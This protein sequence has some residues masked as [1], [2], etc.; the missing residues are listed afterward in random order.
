MRQ[1]AINNHILEIPSSINELSPWQLKR[2]KAYNLTTSEPDAVILLLLLLNPR[3]F[4]IA[5][6]IFYQLEFRPW[7][8]QTLIGKL[9]V[10]VLDKFGKDVVVYFVR[11]EPFLR[12]IMECISFLKEDTTPLSVKPFKYKY[13]LQLFDEFF[14]G[15]TMRQFREAYFELM[16][17]SKNADA[18]IDE[19]NTAVAWLIAPYWLTNLPFLGYFFKKIFIPKTEPHKWCMW[20]ASK[21]DPINKR[22]ILDY[23]D[24]QFERTK[25]L[26][27]EFYKPSDK[28]EKSSNEMS[29]Y[30]SL[31]GLS[32]LRSSNN[33]I[34]DSVDLSSFTDVIESYEI[35]IRRSLQLEE[36]LK[37]NKQ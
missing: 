9:I 26:Y 8:Y 14:A 22:L 6:W 36:E 5:W 3:N 4:K 35:D 18:H 34:E 19:V 31:K 24:G 7:F 27:P 30:Y 2:L 29:S 28:A 32:Q 20:V 16:L 17:V 10:W 37:K 15:L 23:F 21:I 13:G 11:A 1:I 33:L 25:K 12:Q